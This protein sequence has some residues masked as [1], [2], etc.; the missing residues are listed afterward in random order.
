MHAP[1]Q[2]HITSQQMSVS[3]FVLFLFFV[4]LEMSLFRAS[5]IIAV[6]VCMEITLYVFV[7]GGVFL[8]CDHELDFFT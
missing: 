2:P 1:R 4:S 6:F 7:P 8:S 3:S 5:C